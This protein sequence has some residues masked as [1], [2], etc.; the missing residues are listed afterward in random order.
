MV[1]PLGD[2]MVIGPMD[3]MCNHHLTPT[4]GGMDTVNRNL[5]GARNRAATDSVQALEE[6]VG[7][8]LIAFAHHK[9]G[10]EPPYWRE[11]DPHPRIA[12]EREHL[13]GYGEMRFFLAHEAP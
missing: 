8:V 13:F 7:V 3:L 4:S 1:L 10:R 2:A 12:I 9:G 11:G 5:N 6:H